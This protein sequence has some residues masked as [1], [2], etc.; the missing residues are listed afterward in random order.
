VVTADFNRWM[1]ADKFVHD[2]PALSNFIFE[3]VDEGTGRVVHIMKD[4][5]E[6]ATPNEELEACDAVTDSN[7]I[8]ADGVGS[9]GFMTGMNVA[10]REG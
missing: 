1:V 3:G 6:R 5:I 9:N 4:G 8:A 7:H 10:G 2:G